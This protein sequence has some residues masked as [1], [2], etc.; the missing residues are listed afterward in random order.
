[1]EVGAPIPGILRRINE[2]VRDNYSEL[3]QNHAPHLFAN[4]DNLYYLKKTNINDKIRKDSEDLISVKK[5]IEEKPNDII[6]H[7]FHGDIDPQY[8]VS[9]TLFLKANVRGC[10]IS[11]SIIDRSMKF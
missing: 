10:H 5:L 2:N 8:P 4:Y 9:K 7:K 3:K 11:G 1:M 6:Y